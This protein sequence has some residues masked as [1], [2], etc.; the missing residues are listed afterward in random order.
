MS[1]INF[2]LQQGKMTNKIDTFLKAINDRITGALPSDTVKNP[3]LNVNSTSPLLSARSYPTENPQSSSHLL[4]SINAIK[5]FFEQTNKFQNYQPQVKTSTINE[6][7]VPPRKGIKIPS[8]FLSPNYKFQSSFGEQ[9]RNTSSPKRVHF[10]NTISILSK[11][12]KRRETRIIKPDTKDN[13]DDMI[14]K[15]EKESEESEDEKKEEKEEP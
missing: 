9:N 15:V 2:K 5:M 13:N 3:K 12:D 8:K 11:E 14:V 6:N 1:T 7:R 4:H 10:I